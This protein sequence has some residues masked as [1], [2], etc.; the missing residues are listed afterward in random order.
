MNILKQLS[1]QA[2]D[3][4][5][6]SNKRVAARVLKQPALLAEIAIGLASTDTK[7]VGDCAEV[8][9]FVA[10]DKPELVAPYAAALIALIDHKDTR[11]RWEVMHSLAE[12]A[13]QVPKKI[14]PILPRLVE[15]IDRDKSVIVRDYA[16]L[17]LGEYGG[18]SVEAARYVWPHLRKSLEMWEG[19][20]VGKVLEAMQKSA[21]IDPGLKVEVAIIAQ[22]FLEDKRA[23]VRTLAKRLQKG[24]AT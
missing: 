17:A 12:I 11:V 9:T 2:S 14:S 20:H 5:E 23:R 8:M 18:T 1:S 22:R 7:L 21:A 4:T 10:A 13:V 24:A 3:R 16:L 15:K 6:E 19:K